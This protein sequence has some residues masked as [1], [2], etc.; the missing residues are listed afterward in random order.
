MTRKDWISVGIH[1]DVVEG[2]DAFLQT[3]EAKN[4]N[5]KS[6]QEFLNLLARQYLEKYEK[7]HLKP[8]FKKIDPTLFEILGS[9]DKRKG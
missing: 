5:L 2:I 7:L 3:V 8:M 6:R 4:M 9:I 1:T